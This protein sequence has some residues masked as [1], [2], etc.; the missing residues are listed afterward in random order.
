MP[1]ISIIT[2]VY[3][4]MPHLPETVDSVLGQTLDD[5]EYV[6]VDDGSV[7]GTPQYLASIEDD[8]VRVVSL[9]RSGRGVALN[10]GVRESTAE[11]IAIIDADDVCSVRRLEM[12]YAWMRGHEDL[13]V[14]S[15]VCT[16]EQGELNAH[17]S[18]RDDVVPVQ[19]RQLIRRTPIAHSGVIMRRE[20]IESVGGYDEARKNLFD[21]DLW[22]RL[23]A[24]G[25][26]FGKV[27]LPLVYK[28]IHAG[29]NFERGKRLR[30]LVAGFL[31]RMKAAKMFAAS[32]IDYLY[33]FAG[34]VYGMLPV[35]L[36]RRIHPLSCE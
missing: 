31:G 15:C 24:H 23:A 18:D 16:L 29:Q 20:A 10:A 9:P 30:Y 3:N 34:F 6:I 28:R 2:T 22:L 1:K 11:L 32:P 12:Q 19:P 7:D 33:P 27:R 8:R 4:G 25:Y 36:R 21:Y 17:T 35:Y 5:F 26:R 13:D 14:I